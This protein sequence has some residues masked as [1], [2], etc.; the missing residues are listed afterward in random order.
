[1]VI[2]MHTRAFPIARTITAVAATLALTALSFTPFGLGPAAESASAAPLPVGTY[3]QGPQAQQPAS[4]PTKVIMLDL[5]NES[6]SSISGS[7]DAPFQNGTLSAQCGNFAT[8]AMHSTTHPSESNY[9]A[10]VSGLNAAIN[11]GT[12]ALAR[13]GL[14]DCPPDATNS[15]CTFGGGHFAST[16]PSL[17]SQIEQQYGVSGWKTYADDM[18]TPCERNDDTVYATTPSATYRKYVSK[19]NPAVFFQGIACATQDVPSG[20]WRNGQGAL[21]NDLVGGT[22]PAFS[23]IVP[24][25]I[26]NGHD[27]STVNGVTVAGGKNQIANI[28][29]YLSRLMALIQGSPDYQ[30]GNLV[31]MV[32][33]DEGT[34]AGPIA[35]EGAV[36]Q[37]C[38]DP[39]ISAL[40]TSCQVQTWIVGRYVPSYLYPTYMN[41]FGLL[42]A[43]Q[44]I[45][46]LS[47]LLGHAADA[48]TPDIVNGT[49]A[50]PDPFNLVPNGAP[51]APTVPGAPSGLTPT[52]ASSAVS[53]SWVPPTIT[54]GVAISDY[55]VEYRIGGTTTWSAFPHPA[56]TA[57]NANVSGLTNG[58]AYD[59]RVS[60]V[61]SVGTGPPS[62]TV[63]ASPGA[64]GPELLAD[65]GFEA[66]LS[67]WVPFSVGNLTRITNP[68]RSG[69]NA[70][71]IAAVGA[72][73]SK[74]GMTQNS[75]V[76]RTTAGTVYTA[77]CWVQPTGANITVQIHF[78]EYTQN[79]GSYVLLGTTSIP[80]LTTGVWTL[81]KVSSTA[82]ASN[83]RMIP[84]IYSTNQTTSTGS[85]IYD[86]CSVTTGA[87]APVITAPTAPTGV[88]A[89]AANASASVS[90][91][92]PASNGG[93][94]ITSYRVTAT[95][96]G[97]TATGGSS[98]IAIGGLTNGTSYTFAVT[99]TNSAGTGPAS[100][101]SNSVTP[102]SIPDAPGAP[103]TVP[104]DGQV[105][106]SWVAPA[107]NGSAI[108]GYIVHYSVSGAADWQPVAPG[109]GT[110]VTVTSLT[111]GTSYDF[112]VAAV[113]ALGA[114]D[115]SDISAATPAAPVILPPDAPTIG[116]ATAGDGS[117]AVTFT[118][119][120]NTGGD[121]ILDYTVTS[122]PDGLTA[123][124]ASSPV[125]VPGLTNGTS[126]SF[127]VTA[128]TDAGSS[129]PSAASNAVTPGAS[130]QVPGAPS[131]VVATVG[132]RTAT[133]SFVAPASNGGSPITKYTVTSSPGGL[134]V[135]GPSSP[136]VVSGLTN[137]TAYTFTVTAT[138]T[139]GTGAPSAPSAAVTPY[140]E[141]LPDPGFESG[142]GGWI[143]FSVGTLTRV[144]SPVR[145]GL[146]AL[147]VAAVGPTASKVGL[148]QNSVVSKSVAGTN[149]TAQCWVQPTSAN[150][151]VQIHF[152]EYT[153]NFGSYV[154][155]GTTSI[156]RLT[157]GVWTLVKVSSVAV[158]SNERMIPQIY[159]TNETTATGTLIYDDCSV[160]AG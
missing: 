60:A 56:S 41:Q 52:S 129:V 117:A 145:S 106:L 66:G 124:G 140:L 44:R 116:V 94:P 19:H 134:S 22:L 6:S 100:S 151:T 16:V 64:S 70:L 26:D 29:A 51:P 67:G 90:F 50:V 157:M 2:L 32:T 141:L 71:N 112:Q 132:N 59:F 107:S 102:A 143:P 73:A 36:G 5:E 88:N 95:P 111:N 28:D 108:T 156:P 126:Y 109:V 48:S 3:C 58:T 113:N 101:A 114:S 87:G 4:G 17:F 104:G 81:V 1:M 79:F 120:A 21:Y 152:V 119:P 110:A 40:A 98:P 63:S 128:R 159:S 123:T 139:I 148:T 24:N 127:T 155:L 39:A 158:A 115:F 18:V 55:L 146:D 121:P 138:N 86:D 96:G 54:G 131:G 92:P 144:T 93:A 125:T 83:E 65:P 103:T 23:F 99:A 69:T 8:S 49:A 130:A 62:A 14:S 82:V 35:G 53:L 75:V 31:V 76:S 13:F 91:S 34:K 160:S 97:A 27:P 136:L 11:S 47:P 37:N 80:R 57:T 15:F 9:F 84:Q 149:Y 42:A 142:V 25:N 20:D 154:L 85:L 74:V 77:Q 105:A 61:N 137:G 122:A 68:V 89:T 45:L 43:T 33:F 153:Q 150:L 30:S 78:V 72:A 7:P 10:E 135:F 12:D 133:V 118:P 147:S 46:G 38:A